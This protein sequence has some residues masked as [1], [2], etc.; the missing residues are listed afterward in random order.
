V[1]SSLH[2]GLSKVHKRVTSIKEK[3][4]KSK[5][6]SRKISGIHEFA[7]HAISNR[8]IKGVSVV[9]GSILF[10]GADGKTC[11]RLG[12][13]TI[14]SIEEWDVV[15]VLDEKT[16]VV[17]MIIPLFPRLKK[18]SSF[19]FTVNGENGTKAHQST[20]C[21]WVLERYVYCA[22]IDK[23]RNCKHI[24][25]P[26]VHAFNEEILSRRNS[27]QLLCSKDWKKLSNEYV[28]GLFNEIEVDQPYFKA[29]HAK[30]KFP[31]LPVLVG[32]VME[33]HVRD[34]SKESASVIIDLALASIMSLF[35]DR[36]FSVDLSKNNLDKDFKTSPSF[37]VFDNINEFV[38]GSSVC[39]QPVIECPFTLRLLCRFESTKQLKV[40]NTSLFLNFE[41]FHKLLSKNKLGVLTLCI[42]D[43]LSEKSVCLLR[44][45]I[46]SKD[47]RKEQKE[48]AK[49][50][51][52]FALD[53]L[54][55]KRKGR[56][57]ALR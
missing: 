10:Q 29:N 32:K 4:L 48:A 7:R 13:T 22:Y 55:E 9:V 56:F 17:Q 24:L 26:R 23:D 38:K 28:A 40:E 51:A 57:G 53:Q 35:N 1:A 3:L 45:D 44:Y 41:S 2:L 19:S 52:K 50:S 6:A 49:N 42:G 34:H 54:L 12:K 36:T 14:E 16:Q 39:E 5:R 20:G 27:E 25:F 8:H 43:H 11:D 15:L 18:P 47:E 33:K 46:L 31:W 30:N 37:T 21:Q